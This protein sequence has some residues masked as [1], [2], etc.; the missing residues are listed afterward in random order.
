MVL[1]SSL[2]HLIGHMKPLLAV[3]VASVLISQFKLSTEKQWNDPQINGALVQEASRH[4]RLFSVQHNIFFPAGSQTKSIR[5][6]I[7]PGMVFFF[8][9]F[10]QQKAILVNL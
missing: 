7:S 9:L 4:F 8:F 6:F 3:T 10:D 1:S 2:P 5:L